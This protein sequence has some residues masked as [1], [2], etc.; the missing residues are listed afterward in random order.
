MKFNL[1]VDA[2]EKNKAATA[3]VGPADVLKAFSAADDPCFPCFV[4][5][6]STDFSQILTLHQIAA[7]AAGIRLA[8][9][10]AAACAKSSPR[11]SISV[12]VKSKRTCEEP[13]GHESLPLAL[14]WGPLSEEP[15]ITI[16]ID[17]DCCL[18]LNGCSSLSFR[19]H[20]L[21]QER[22]SS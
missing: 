22:I 12:F 6:P 17:L 2:R 7:L 10:S 18:Q 5:Y 11:P 16:F 13:E 19:M 3:R 14:I 20:F 8:V 4:I 21:L 1:V 15:G 9:C